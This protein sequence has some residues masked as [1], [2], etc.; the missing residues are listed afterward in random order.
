MDHR[1]RQIALDVH[2]LALDAR[3]RLRPP[4][5]ALGALSPPPADGTH[6]DIG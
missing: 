2:H 6:A 5:R 1:F 4:A 3:R